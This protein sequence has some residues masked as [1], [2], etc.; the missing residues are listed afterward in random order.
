MGNLHG[1]RVAITGSRKMAEMSMMVQKKGGTALER[2]LQ[3]TIK[4]T[5]ENMKASVDEVI[6]NGTDWSVFTT[7]IGTSAVFEAAAELGL[8]EPFYK[9]V[10]ASQIAARGYKTVQ[11]LKKH[12]LKPAAE[13]SDG[14]NAGLLQAI[15]EVDLQEC[16]VFLQLHGEPAPALEQGFAAKGAKMTYILPYKT[17]VPQPQT[18]TQLVKEVIAGD[19][20]A[21]L[22]TATPQVRVL[23]QEAVKQGLAE[24]LAEAFNERAAAGSVGRV[25]TGTLNEYGVSRVIAPDHER[26]GAL[27]VAVNEFFKEN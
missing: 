7:G 2:P 3:E 15:E 9:A 20:D 21:V 4:C 14:T 22:F 19:M 16:R 10:A 5:A 26:M 18:V 8:A 1:K 24:E 6:E 17:T 12:G 25:T 11:E 13:D 27:V 23:F